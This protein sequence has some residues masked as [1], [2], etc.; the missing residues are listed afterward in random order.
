MKK[1]DSP[2]DLLYTVAYKAGDI[3][4]EA[5]KTAKKTVL[6]TIG[7]GDLIVLTSLHAATDVISHGLKAFSTPEK[8]TIK[9]YP[10]PTCHLKFRPL[11]E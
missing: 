3:A 2:Q 10:E 4:Q 11:K 1:T 7:T 6:E 8:L 9:P 5:N